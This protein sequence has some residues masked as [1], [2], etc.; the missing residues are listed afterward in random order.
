M[1][2][3]FTLIELMI[4]IGIIAL[5]AAVALP[6]FS[7]ASEAAKAA[8]VQGNLSSIRTSISVY[9]AREKVYPTHGQAGDDLS[10]GTDRYGQLSEKFQK[11]FSKSQM[12]ATPEGENVT[13][14]WE[15]RHVKVYNTSSDDNGG[16]RYDEATGEI[17]ACLPNTAYGV[18]I[19]WTE[20]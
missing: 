6:K 11:Y 13:I 4:V 15:G 14:A 8:N 9:Y 20:E 18:D 7:S 1:K 17:R 3:G 10:R 19:D 2:K 5:L 12:P 16:W